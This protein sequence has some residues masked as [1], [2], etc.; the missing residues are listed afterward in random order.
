MLTTH[1]MK[2]LQWQQKVGC[3]KKRGINLWSFT[4][5]TFLF[6]RAPCLARALVASPSL[7]SCQCLL[8]RQQQWA[9]WATAPAASCHN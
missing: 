5:K 2:S 6:L 7:V 9:T 1:Q 8:E 3:L 4:S